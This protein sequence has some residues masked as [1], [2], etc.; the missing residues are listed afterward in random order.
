M[1]LCVASAFIRVQTATIVG[2]SDR[3]YLLTLTS[4][5]V[6]NYQLLFFSVSM[7]LAPA[8]NMPS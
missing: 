5:T 6:N 4:T 8:P 3:V 2:S 7:T 1:C